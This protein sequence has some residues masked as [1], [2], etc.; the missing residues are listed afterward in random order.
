MYLRK[1]ILV[2]PAPELMGCFGVGIL[3]RQK[4]NDGLLEK[5]TVDL[6]AL[7]ER[8]IEYERMFTCKSCENLCPIQV[9]KVNGHRYSFGG[10]CNKY[11]NTR[12]KI[13]AG[14]QVFDYVEKRTELIFTTCAPDPDTFEQKRD[15]VVGIPSAFSV[16]SLNPL[17]SWFFH[18][19]GIKTLRSDTVEH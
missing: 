6:D 3:A 15:F 16:Y 18:T 7:I 9:L 5:I 10:R 12:K 4:I 8:E 17:Y 2:P 19:L 11:T 13:D 14:S 1:E